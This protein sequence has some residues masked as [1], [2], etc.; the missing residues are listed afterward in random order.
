M[1]LSLALLHVFLTHP[2]PHCGHKLEKTGSYFRTVSHYRC[3]ACRKDVH[4]GYEDKVDLFDKH[5]YLA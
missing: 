1:S 5:A 3:G 2:C 4:I